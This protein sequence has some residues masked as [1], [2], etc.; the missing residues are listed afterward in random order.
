MWVS[1]IILRSSSQ[2]SLVM[3]IACCLGWHKLLI[4]YSKYGEKRLSCFS[5]S[6]TANSKVTTGGRSSTVFSL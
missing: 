4:F 5:D 1:I 6:G 2:L 3:A